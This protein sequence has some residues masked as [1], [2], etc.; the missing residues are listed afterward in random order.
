[1]KIKSAEIPKYSLYAFSRVELKLAFSWLAG[2]GLIARQARKKRNILLEKNTIS[3]CKKSLFE[4][5][6]YVFHYQQD[7]LRKNYTAV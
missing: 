2:Y 5:F 7:T 3:L 6:F 4:G 1:M